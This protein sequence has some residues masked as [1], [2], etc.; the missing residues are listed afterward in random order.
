[1]FWRSSD[2]GPHKPLVGGSNPPA[3][4]SLFSGY[5]AE[6]DR[7]KTLINEYKQRKI[8]GGIYR[9]TNTCNGMYLF[10]CATNLQAKQNAF[11]FMVSSGSCFHYKL[12][13][14]WAA[15]GGKAFNFEMLEALEK[16]KDQTNDEFIDDLKVLAQLWS[17]KLD[18]SKR[19]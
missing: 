13:K 5:Q 12:K 9:V 8:I 11:D 17:E 16:K 18:S 10:G 7:R 3:A 14:D 4:S 1:M 19:Y 15:F 2:P 6:M